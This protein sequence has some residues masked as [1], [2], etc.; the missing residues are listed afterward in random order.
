VRKKFVDIFEASDEGG[1][2]CL[3]R[4]EGVAD[5]IA[6]F[7]EEDV[8]MG[9]AVSNGLKCEMTRAHEINDLRW[10]SFESPTKEHCRLASEDGIVD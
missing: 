8:A 9:T 10:S 1:G 4:R 2:R 3:N 6:G 5:R 7:D